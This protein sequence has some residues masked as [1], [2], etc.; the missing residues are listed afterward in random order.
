MEF[1]LYSFRIFGNLC[2]SLHYHTLWWYIKMPLLKCPLMWIYWNLCIGA[3][4][5]ESPGDYQIHCCL[6]H[7]CVCMCVHVYV[8]V[9]VCVSCLVMSDS[10]RPTGL[11]PTTLLCPWDPPGKN[12]G[13]DCHALLK[14]Q[15]LTKPYWKGICS[16]FT[17]RNTEHT[18]T[19]SCSFRGRGWGNSPLPFNWPIPASRGR[20]FQSV[21]APPL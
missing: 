2:V 8:C 1:E 3:S 16:H 18:Y 5:R 19:K 17:D 15:A 9:C 4:S 10:V 7:V 14:S 20:G 21:S 13:V 12:T 6:K 11:W